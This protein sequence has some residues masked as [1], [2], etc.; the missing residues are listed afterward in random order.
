[1]LMFSLGDLPPGSAALIRMMEK[2]GRR[3]LARMYRSSYA[4]RAS[5]DAKQVA[6]WQFPIAVHRLTDGIPSERHK[7]VAVIE[8]HLSPADAARAREESES[9]G[10]A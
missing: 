3:V 9:M 2:F 4:E 6:R 5:L 1:M 7:L 10:A 8:R